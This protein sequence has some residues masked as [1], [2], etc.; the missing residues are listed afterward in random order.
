MSIV[1][2]NTAR[3]LEPAVSISVVKDLHGWIMAT[4]LT[5][6]H[7]NWDFGFGSD[8][9]SILGIFELRT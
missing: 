1:I 4:A 5:D 6:M 3:S 8:F 7:F 9:N 2:Y